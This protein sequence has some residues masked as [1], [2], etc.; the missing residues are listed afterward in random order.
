MR[1]TSTELTAVVSR[2]WAKWTKY[3]TTFNDR[4]QKR[5]TGEDFSQMK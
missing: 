3:L 1:T 5:N 2:H 4:E